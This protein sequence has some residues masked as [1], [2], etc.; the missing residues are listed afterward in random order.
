MLKGIL[1][2]SGYPG[3]YRLVTEARNG[4]IV[5]SLVTGKRMN[6]FPSAKVSAL[7]DISIFTQ[8]GDIGLLSVLRAIFDKNQGQEEP[9]FTDQEL[10][11]LFETEILPDYD[12]NR[13]YL[14]DMKKIVKWYNMLIE[15]D[16]LDFDNMDEPVADEAPPSEK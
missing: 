9:A 4:I 1:A 10:K 2:I 7:A 16:L 15:N 11:N 14:S 13:F 3:L 6:V 8:T 5:E 12:R